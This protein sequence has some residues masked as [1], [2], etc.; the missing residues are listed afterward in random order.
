MNAE[1]KQKW[2]EALRSDK[3]EQV[4]GELYQG[5]NGVVRCCAL[6]V[7]NDI[8]G[9][10]AWD[11]NKQYYVEDREDFD[12]DAWAC[13]VF[14]HELDEFYDAST[15]ETKL[16]D[17]DNLEQYDGNLREHIRQCFHFEE[18]A[19]HPAVMRWAGLERNDPRITVDGKERRTT[20]LPWT[21]LYANDNGITFDK[22]A[23]IIEE[24]L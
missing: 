21:I 19:L 23:D 11:E 3:Y 7:L 17:L 10:G 13:M 22:L 5:R 9:L 4:M 20:K 18:E 14:D 12:E 2:V 8:S 1:V 15:T 6:G 16:P 24:Q